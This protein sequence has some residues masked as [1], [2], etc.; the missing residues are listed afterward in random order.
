MNKL[1]TTVKSLLSVA[2]FAV[3]TAAT[4][5]TAAPILVNGVGDSFS[6]DFS[7]LSS[8]GLP[9]SAESDWLVTAYTGTTITF[10]VD[11]TNTSTTDPAQLTAFSFVT[12]PDAT[13]GTST[14][15]IFGN[16][17]TAGGGFEVCVENDTN[18]NCNG[19]T[20]NPLESLGRGDSDSF[21][22]TLTFGSTAGGVTLSGFEARLQGIG[23]QGDS[24][25]IPGEPVCEGDDCDV[26]VPEPASLALFGLAA[27]AA[28]AVRRRKK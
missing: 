25:K 24:A 18:D 13:A 1:S 17:Y 2:A 5:A 14:S 16:V 10:A 21:E 8:D 26:T 28:G 4:P 7:G 6:V 11:I 12:N 19:N 9:V 20:G 27:L 23:P 15:T 3:A 22:L